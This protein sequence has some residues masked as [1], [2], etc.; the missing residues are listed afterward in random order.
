MLQLNLKNS[1]NCSIK[2]VG[3]GGLLEPKS[4]LDFGNSGTAARLI[5]G[6][7]A[8]HPITTLYVGDSSL[9][10]DQWIEF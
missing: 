4:A 3:L 10:I 7:S 9:S 6:L 1:F 8:S 2:G 5:M